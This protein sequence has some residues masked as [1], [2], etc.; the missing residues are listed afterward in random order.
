M[1]ILSNTGYFLK[2]TKIIVQ[3]NLLSHIFSLLS[4]GLIVFILAM[5][6]SGWW[7]SSQVVAAIQGEAEINAYFDENMAP[8]AVGQLME[9][10]KGIPGVREVRLV[11]QEEAYERMVEILGKEARVLSLFDENPFSPFLE[12]KI[13]LAEMD[14]ILKGLASMPGIESVRDNREVL[15]RLRSMAGVLRYLGCLI[16]AAVGISVLVIVSHIIRLGIYNNREQINTLRL[17]GA[18]EIFIAFPFVLEGLFLTL[19]GSIL[20]AAMS[21]LA[22]KFVYAQ[23]A[24]PLPFIPLPPLDLLVTG[25]VIL[26]ISLGVLLGIAGS[27]FGLLSARS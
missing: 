2:E 15:D 5:V 12:V 8:G 10:M 24:G 19:G 18:P 17:L 1:R 3:L 11:D 27:L 14:P 25:L 26:V 16:V 9:R 6:I 7:V 20:A 21:G 23:M 4:T 22:L 13:D